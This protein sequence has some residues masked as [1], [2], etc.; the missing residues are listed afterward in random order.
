M[1]VNNNTHDEVKF[2]IGVKQGQSPFSMLFGLYSTLMNLEHVWTRLTRILHIYLTCLL[3]FF[4]MRR[5]SLCSLNWEHAC[6]DSFFFETKGRQASAKAQEVVHHLASFPSSR[7]EI[8]QLGFKPPTSFLRF[9]Y[10]S[11]ITG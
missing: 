5:M 6:I 10:P 9:G 8:S 1:Q 2:D 11:T 4:S 7:E 3:P